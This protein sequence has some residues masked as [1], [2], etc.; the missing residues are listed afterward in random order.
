MQAVSAN[1]GIGALISASRG[2]EIRW[3]S[4][5]DWFSV[6]GQ[7]GVVNPTERIRRGWRLGLRPVR[8]STNANM[9]VRAHLSVRMILAC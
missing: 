6:G 3:R 7:R 1:V 8:G 9:R 4:P 5:S 2:A